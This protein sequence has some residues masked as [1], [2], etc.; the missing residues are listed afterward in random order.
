VEQQPGDGEQS[1]QD[2]RE[3]YQEKLQ[4]WDQKRIAVNELRQ[5]VTCCYYLDVPFDKTLRRHATKPSPGS[6]IPQ[7]KIVLRIMADSGLA[8]GFGTVV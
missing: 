5:G 1:G 6:E 3:H 8:A 2:D 4:I 7:D